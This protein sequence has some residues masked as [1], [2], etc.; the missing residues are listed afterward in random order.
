L[1]A[2]S[3]QTD[4]AKLLLA[5]KS[6]FNIHD[7]AACGDVEKVKALLKEKPNLVFSTDDKSYNK[8]E[9]PLHWAARNGQKDTAALLLANKAEVNAKDT[10]G[11]TPLHSAVMNNRKDLAELLLANKAEVDARDNSGKTPLHEAAGAG[12]KDLVELLLGA[13]T[14][15]SVCDRQD[16]S[17][18]E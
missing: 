18:R 14:E 1:A 4:V 10:G 17:E 13:K 5:N 16:V 2:A 3:G 12:S 8:N 6:E 15:I 9:T 7:A 11:R